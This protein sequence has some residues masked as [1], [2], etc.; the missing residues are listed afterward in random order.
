M[1][2][3]RDLLYFGSGR[4]TRLPFLATVKFPVIIAQRNGPGTILV[5]VEWEPGT[6]KSDKGEGGLLVFE[7]VS[8]LG[9]F[10]LF[11]LNSVFLVFFWAS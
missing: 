7:Q 9:H 2:E 6:S 3:R 11:G 4:K 10:E 8:I 5:P 1:K